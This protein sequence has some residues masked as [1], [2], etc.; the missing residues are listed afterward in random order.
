M[1]TTANE[2]RRADGTDQPVVGSDTPRTD[3]ALRGSYADLHK[4]SCDLE[5]ELTEARAV[6][7]LIQ[8]F[9]GT[10]TDDAESIHCGGLWCAE[11]ARAFLAAANK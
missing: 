7:Y 6:L 4:C 11:Q 10:T 5:R 8:D 9:G 2:P 1:T 3:A